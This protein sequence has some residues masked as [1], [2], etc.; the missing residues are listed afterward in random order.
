MQLTRLHITNFKNIA[1]A[2]LSFSP[3]INALLGD[4]GMGKSN[5]LDAIYYLSF[6]KSFTGLPDA[7]VVRA[8]ET[9][10]MMQGDYLRRGVEEQ[11][12]FG[13]TAGK[14]KSFKRGGKEYSRLSQHIGLF[15][16]V[17]V[18]PADMEL[19]S[20]AAEVRR[21]FIDM[22]ISQTDPAY[23]SHLIRYNTSLQQRNRMLRDHIADPNLYLAVEMGM[24]MSADYITNARQSIT[25]RLSDIFRRH[26]RDIARTDE[27]PGIA[28]TSAMAAS[29]R[30]FSELLDEARRKDEIVGHTTV[31]PHRDDLVLTLDSMPVKSTA[32]QG[33]SKTF[34]I[35][36]RLAQYEFMHEATGMRPLLLLDDIFDKLDRNRVANI[37]DIVNR[38]IFG[39]IFITDTNRDHLDT[40]MSS[41]PGAD[42]RLW[43]VTSG[44]FQQIK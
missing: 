31:G 12:Q 21:R 15:P 11:V 8:G 10:A 7:G 4:N 29:G 35:A 39:Q 32:S 22:L 33:Q 23:L 36:L 1:D 3:N 30:R 20:G 16:L 9:F 14:R 5:L 37:I 28:Y 17:L 19:V 26:Y 24:E 38:D 40:I 18:S 6:C 25:S 43:N 44:S 42:Y 13:Y 27:M 41:M 2:R 34:T